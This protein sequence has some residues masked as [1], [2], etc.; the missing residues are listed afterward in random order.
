MELTGQTHIEQRL[1]KLFHIFIINLSKINLTF[2]MSLN[3]HSI[4]VRF[5]VLVSEQYLSSDS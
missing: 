1:V 4:E 2:F 5:D 3:T